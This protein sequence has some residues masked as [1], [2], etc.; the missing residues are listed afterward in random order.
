MSRIATERETATVAKW[1]RRITR[2]RILVVFVIA[3]KG[4]WVI[5]EAVLRMWNRL[6]RVRIV[7]GFTLC[8]GFA[9]AF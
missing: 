7:R 3:A 9:I 5:S 4:A 6:V 2:S 8:G 1:S